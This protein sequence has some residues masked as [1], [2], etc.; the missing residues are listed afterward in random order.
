MLGVHRADRAD[1]QSALLQLLPDLRDV[2]PNDVAEAEH[3]M[4]RE[5]QAGMRSDP[6]DPRLEVLVA[7]FGRGALQA[8]GIDEVVQMRQAAARAIE[9]RALDIDLVELQEKQLL[10][11][12]YGHLA[13]HSTCAAPDASSSS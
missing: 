4:L 12:G 13:H 5:C 11:H 3:A 1:F 8:R 9:E 10:S 2:A 6:L 7:L